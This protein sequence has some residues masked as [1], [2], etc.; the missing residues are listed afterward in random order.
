MCVDIMYVC[1]YVC[2]QS[3]RLSTLDSFK[4][5]SQTYPSVPLFVSCILL[6]P[7]WRSLSLP[8]LAPFLLFIL[9]TLI[10]SSRCLVGS[11]M[12]LD[13]DFLFTNTPLDDSPLPLRTKLLPEDPRVHLTTDVFLQL[14]RL[15]VES[16]SSSFEGRFHSQTFGVAI[17]CLSSP[18][19][20]IMEY[21]ESHLLPSIYLHLSV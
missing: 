20:L 1:I 11:R 21:F 6:R 2:P 16:N 7:G 18:G 17:P 8:S 5:I 9:A 19:K 12:S 15:C 14:V 3:L 13:V 4:P 10:I